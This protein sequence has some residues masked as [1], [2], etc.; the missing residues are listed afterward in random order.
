MSFEKFLKKHF[1]KRTSGKLL[2]SCTNCRNSITR[3]SKKQFHKCFSRTKKEPS[4]IATFRILKGLK[5]CWSSGAAVHRCF[6]KQVFLKTSQYW[7]LVLI[8][9]QAFFCKKPKVAASGFLRQQILFFSWIWYLLL[10]VAPG[11]F[12]GLFWKQE[13]NLRSSQW[14]Y[15]VQKCVL[16]NFAGNFTGKHLCSSLFL[17]ELQA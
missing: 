12:S 17:I 8:K 14:S 10:A 7:C 15:S 11:F 16:I 6:S 2:I 9:L 4:V 3:Y 13:L 1:L 5:G